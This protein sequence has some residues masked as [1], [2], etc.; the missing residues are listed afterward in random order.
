M[1]WTIGALG[2]FDD[3]VKITEKTLKDY[4]LVEDAEDFRTGKKFQL[5]S[6]IKLDEKRISLGKQVRIFSGVVVNEWIRTPKILEQV[7][8]GAYRIVSGEPIKDTQ[9]G[10]FWLTTE[11]IAVAQSK[12]SR[13]FSFDLLSTAL[14]SKVRP[15][16]FR[17]SKIAD[18]YSG[19]WLGGF[20]DR[21]GR[22]QSGTIYGDSLEEE[23]L[24][25]RE[26]PRWK[27][28]QVGFQT[29]YFGALTK[30]KV[31]QE[32]VVSAYRDLYGDMEQFFAFVKDELLKYIET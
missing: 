5:T 27:K 9:L 11:G 12:R 15:I 7:E 25:R 29:K 8:G 26:Y 31:T 13:G 4:S 30:V 19:H 16:K 2:L 1:V 23:R 28:K 3:S 18:D 24:I 6:A 32:G 21:K 22:M 17:V 20:Y 14:L 10:Q